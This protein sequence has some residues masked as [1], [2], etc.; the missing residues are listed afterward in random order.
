MRRSRNVRRMSKKVARRTK[1][2]NTTKNTTKDTIKNTIKNTTKRTSRETLRRIKKKT[3]NRRINGRSKRRSKR[4]TNKNSKRKNNIVKRGGANIKNIEYI[5]RIH[6]DPTQIEGQLYYF[7]DKLM[8]GT[9]HMFK[10]RGES[11]GT[12]YTFKP[13]QLIHIKE[14]FV[15]GLNSRTGRAAL[16]TETFYVPRILSKITCARIKYIPLP[17]LVEGMAGGRSKTL[18]YMGDKKKGKILLG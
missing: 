12:D 7:G 5:Q 6:R 1:R 10:V 8:I 4:R 3:N 14:I 11:P 13:R 9:G 17:Y 15:R 2:K 18:S 16:V